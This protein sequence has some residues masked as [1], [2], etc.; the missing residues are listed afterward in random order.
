[1]LFVFSL[2]FIACS[3]KNVT[4][5]M[6]SREHYEYAMKFF[7]K[8]NYI[9][10]ADEFSL[11]TYKFSG[12]DIADDAQ[13]YLSE[14]YFRQKDYVSASSE[15]DRLVSSFPRSE[16]VERGMYN[17]VICYNELSPGF[18][19]DQ[20]FTYEAVQAIQNFQD[21]YPKSEKKAEVD[22]IFSTI[23]LKLARKHFESANIYRKVSEF[24]AAIVYY[25]QVIIDYYD[26]PYAG[27]SKFWK[28]YC[29]FKIGEFQKAT[30]IIKKFID[31]YPQEKKLIEDAQKLLV[32]IKEKEEKERNKKR[33]SVVSETIN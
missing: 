24:E 15:Y 12:S 19:L 2:L 30:L 27:Q 9:K 29:N 4:Q 5:Y 18:A 23:K 31:D 21:L 16:F 3:K 13:Y 25:D 22:S 33:T 10:A 32:K 14:C 20:K 17:L 11:I 26:S 7:N 1:V 6:T 28:G 8:K